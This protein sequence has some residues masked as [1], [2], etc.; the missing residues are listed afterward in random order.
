MTFSTR[1]QEMELSVR[2]VSKFVDVYVIHV[3]NI[4]IFHNLNGLKMH[5]YV[6]TICTRA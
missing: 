3:H 4:K 1:R 6:R 2:M 5:M